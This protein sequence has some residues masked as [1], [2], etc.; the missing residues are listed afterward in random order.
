VN[1]DL[2]ASP[3]RTVEVVG[4][5][6]THTLIE[7]PHLGEIYAEVLERHG[8]PV[9]PD[10]VLRLA[11]MVW[12]E[13]GCS[14]PVGGERFG[15]HSEGERGF[16]RHYLERLC[17]LLDLAPPSRFAAAELY[18]RFGRAD[19]WRVYPDVLPAL[20]AL[21]RAGLRLVV[22]SNWDSR[23]PGLLERLGLL[24]FF[25]A[26]VHSSAIGCEKPGAAIF[27][28]AARRMDVLPGAVLHVGDHALE[29]V[30]GARAVGMQALLLER[31]PR[32]AADASAAL[33]MR[34]DSIGP[35]PAMRAD[36]I[37]PL[38][39]LRRLDELPERLG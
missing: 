34:A 37:G 18:D 9:A 6:V 35:L 26:V 10:E 7:T 4:L 36:S 21:R 27:H 20:T 19:A 22:I 12:Q 24:P 28:E 32:R 29:D 23:L 38:P 15:L 39:V 11:P 25:D 16:W 17:A 13:L 2:G 33:A 31:R 8:T 14:V 5:D 3:L 30:E 1:A